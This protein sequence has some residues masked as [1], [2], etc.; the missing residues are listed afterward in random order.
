MLAIT[1]SRTGMR[2]GKRRKWLID[3]YPSQVERSKIVP[4]GRGVSCYIAP[5][6]DGEFLK[7]RFMKGTSIGTRR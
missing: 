1:P 5:R 6:I 3:K 2:V 7:G 4:T